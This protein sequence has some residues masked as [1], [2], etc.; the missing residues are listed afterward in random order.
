SGPD[1]REGM[2]ELFGI[3][4]RK[5][6]KEVTY[7]RVLQVSDTAVAITGTID[8]MACDD[9]RCV[10]P[11]PL[12]FSIVPATGA[13]IIGDTPGTMASSGEGCDLRLA[14]VDLD[15]PVLRGDADTIDTQVRK[16]GALWNVFLLG[17]IGGRGALPPPGGL[18]VVPPTAG[19][20][21]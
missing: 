14:N 9:A 17:F 16:G 8:Y 18:P 15:A 11:D 1:M 20:V 6:K 13:A 2:D 5:I 4:V 10:F 19:L 12:K 3:K 21:R 7:S